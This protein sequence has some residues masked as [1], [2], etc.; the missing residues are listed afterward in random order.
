MWLKMNKRLKQVLLAFLILL[1]GGGIYYYYYF[2]GNINNKNNPPKNTTALK[3]VLTGLDSSK[4]KTEPHRE[5]NLLSEMSSDEIIN[6]FESLRTAGAGLDLIETLLSQGKDGLALDLLR[7]LHELCL[8]RFDLFYQ[9]AAWAHTKL[10]DYCQDYTSDLY[11]TWSDK[12]LSLPLHTPDFSSLIYDEDRTTIDAVSSEFLKRLTQISSRRVRSDISKSLAYFL[13]VFDAP[14][15]LG[16]SET[17]PVSDLV[18]VQHT[19]IEI[20]FCQRFGGCG[21]DGNITL[22]ACN[23]TGQCHPGWSMMDFYRNTISPLN[24]EQ[25]MNIVNEINRQEGLGP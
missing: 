1:F 11:A 13:N 9:N 18:F 16:Q 24:F 4:L 8:S 3:P 6:R 2:D 12:P 14:L 22:V 5:S 23:M 21:P 7:T 25:V 20:Y 19:A 17:L 15:Q 10:T